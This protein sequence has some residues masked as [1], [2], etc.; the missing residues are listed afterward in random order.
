MH[1]VRDLLDKQLL[2]REGNKIGQVDGLVIELR[3][4]AQPK[5]DAIETGSGVVLDRLG[6]RTANRRYRIPYT[7]V[8]DVDIAVSLDVD[9]TEM[10]VTRWQNWLRQ[11]ILRWIPGGLS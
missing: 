6:W 3:Q 5:I 4:G 1:L 11:N 7:K 10:P 8:R 9:R 2:D